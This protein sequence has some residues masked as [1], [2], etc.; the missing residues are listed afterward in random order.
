[1]AIVCTL[2]Y[3]KPNTDM[4]KQ[5]IDRTPGVCISLKC[6]QTL[7]HLVDETSFV[8]T[9]DLTECIATQSLGLSYKIIV[10]NEDF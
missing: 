7:K 8:S 3:Y 4:K 1:M 5:T 10:K 2:V 9:L 6:Q